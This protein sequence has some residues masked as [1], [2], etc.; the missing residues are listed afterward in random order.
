MGSYLTRGSISRLPINYNDRVGL[1]ICKVNKDS[2]APD[3]TIAFPI[4]WGSY[5]DYGQISSA[6]N[7]LSYKILK[8]EIIKKDENKMF[9]RLQDLNQDP[10]T[11]N[12]FNNYLDEEDNIEYTTFLEHESVLRT[13]IEYQNSIE[14][15]KAYDDQVDFSKRMSEVEKGKESIDDLKLYHMWSESDSLKVFSMIPGFLRIRKEFCSLLKENLYNKRL[16]EEYLDVVKLKRSMSDTKLD[17]LSS[18]YYSQDNYSDLWI[19]MVDNYKE[20]ITNQLKK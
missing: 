8:D 14:Y 15:S 13:L 4:I 20:I 6:D 7:T 16:K 10:E 1:I 19:N 9:S 3:P 11:N 2:I 18:D 12:F 17:F 5:W